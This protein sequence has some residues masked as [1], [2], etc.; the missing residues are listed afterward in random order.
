MKLWLFQGQTKLEKRKTTIKTQCLAPVYNE[1]FQFTVPAKEKLETE[2][3]L[4][5][6][7]SLRRIALKC[8][9]VLISTINKQLYERQPDAMHMNKRGKMVKYTAAQFNCAFC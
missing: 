4:L 7:V 9:S 2:V 1:C 6:T 8:L 5:I 3:N